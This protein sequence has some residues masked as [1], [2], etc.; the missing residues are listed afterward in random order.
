MI[1]FAKY[2]DFGHINEIL[3]DIHNMHVKNE[4]NYYKKV[5][6]V[7]S[8][9]EFNEEIDKKHV[10]IY[11]SDNAILVYVIFSEM[12]INHHPMIK[13]QK[14]LFIDDICVL[15]SE[16]GKGIGR[17]LFNY[18]ENYAKDNLYTNIDLNVWSF[19]VNAFKFYKSMGMRETRIKMSK[20]IL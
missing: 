2:D 19:N 15:H 17:Q 10:I 13:D 8:K 20:N 4:P 14:V 11:E 5:D 12:I 6:E 18:I 16:R 9:K 3:K 7:I 1:R